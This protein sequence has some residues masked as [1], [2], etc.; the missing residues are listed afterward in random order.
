MPVASARLS[1]SVQ[2]HDFARAHRVFQDGVDHCEERGIFSHSAYIR[3]YYTAYEFDRA[4]WTQA[5]RIATEL[6]KSSAVTG[7]Q[8]RDYHDHPCAGAPTP[9]HSRTE[10]VAAASARGIVSVDQPPP[11]NKQME[12]DFGRAPCLESLEVQRVS[13]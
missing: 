13:L 8:Q 10:A 6:M 5:A 2:I 9:M 1:Y 4:E 12:I 7:I 11:Y 3:A